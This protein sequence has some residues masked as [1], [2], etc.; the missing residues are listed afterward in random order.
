[1]IRFL[2]S[3]HYFGFPREVLLKQEETLLE[4]DMSIEAWANKLE[5]ASNYLVSAQHN[6]LEHVATNMLVHAKDLQI[7]RGT[8]F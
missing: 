7:V 2:R 3:P 8:F 6:L 4:F 5:E 1:M